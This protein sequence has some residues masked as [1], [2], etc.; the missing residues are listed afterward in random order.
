VFTGVPAEACGLRDPARKSPHGPIQLSPGP[1]SL[2]LPS[3]KYLKSGSTLK[4]VPTNQWVTRGLFKRL[5]GV[6]AYPEEITN[7]RFPFGRNQAALQL[8]CARCVLDGR[9]HATRGVRTGVLS[10]TG[11]VGYADMTRTNRSP[12]FPGRF[13]GELPL[14]DRFPPCRREGAERSVDVLELVLGLLVVVAALVTVA[15]KTLVP[16]PVVLVL[17][18]L[19]LALVPGLPHVQLD[20]KLVFVLFLPPLV[21]QAAAATSLRDLRAYRRSIS[22]LAVGLV[23]ITML[24]VALV[25]HEAMGIPWG[26]AAVLGI[27]VAPPDAVAAIAVARHLH[28]PK[29]IVTILEAEGLLNDATAFVT[30]RMAVAAVVTGAFSMQEASLRFVWSAAGGV[31]FG[32]L[33]GYVVAWV[34]DHLDDPPVAITISLLTPFAAYIPAEA[35]GVSGIVATV[36]T[37]LY[38][39]RRL[40]LIMEA[41]TRLQTYAV[42]DMVVFIL[43]GLA[44]ILIGLQLPGIVAD[45]AAPGGH[46]PLSEL[47]RDALL[48]SVVI[49][50]VRLPW[51]FA[52]AYLPGALSPRLRARDPYPP[53]QYVAVVAWAGMRGV[54]SLATALALPLVTGQG[55]PFPDR[56]LILFLT[57]CVIFATLVLQGLSLGP[58][59]RWLRLKGDDLA[60]REEVV[61]H[62]KLSQ[63]GSARLE[64]LAREGGIP[65]RMLEVF[66]NDYAERIRRYSSEREEVDVRDSAGVDQQSTLYRRVRRKL[67]G[68]ERLELIRLRDQGVI[69][70]EVLRSVQRALDLEESL[71]AE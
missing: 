59:I 42:W 55:S 45:L 46:W 32:L 11:G 65:E 15:R 54:D 10:P 12:E 66:R 39:G 43:N 38:V 6:I 5:D 63:A 22:S 64:D 14:A 70:E 40:P 49:I 13:S 17:G 23:L 2:A 24:V 1:S 31:F 35:V 60:E 61:A 21:Y 56:A 44:F 19:A 68:A 25:A 9:Q 3:V 62:L 20:P 8:Q 7:P 48:I 67:L 69:G 41:S 18:G 71:L 28:V 50:V 51:V 4:R 33:V 37:G 26:P 53:W 30:Y 36:A 58:I 47:I 34:R 57:F 16:Y 52:T 27:I 29:R